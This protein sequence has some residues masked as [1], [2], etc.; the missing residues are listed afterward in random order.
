M[1][2]TSG[3]QQERIRRMGFSH[4]ISSGQVRNLKHVGREETGW[5]GCLRASVLTWHDL[6]IRRGY[7]VQGNIRCHK[8]VRLEEGCIVCGDVI[9]DGSVYVGRYVRVYGSISAGGNIQIRDEAVI[10]RKEAPQSVRTKRE[11][12]LSEKCCIY[13]SVSART[14]IRVFA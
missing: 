1:E 2:W 7:V 8:N 11:C 5:D 13:G 10:G 3:K 14:K 4:L 9:A 6:V 12:K